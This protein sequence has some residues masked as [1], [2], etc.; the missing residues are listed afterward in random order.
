MHAISSRQNRFYKEWLRVAQ[1]AGG[2]RSNLILL[3]G[4]HLCSAWLQHVGAPNA[5]LL[6]QGHINENALTELCE[7]LAHD[8]PIYALSS[9]LFEGLSDVVSPQG[10]IFVVPKPTPLIPK[11]INQTCV[12]LDRIQDPGNLG[13]ILRT[14]AALEIKHVFLTPGTVSAWS[15]KVLRSAQGAHFLTAI[16]EQVDFAQWVRVLKIPLAL[17][18]LDSQSR[19][20]Y[21]SNLQGPIAWAFGNESQGVDLHWLS[22]AKHR[23]IIPHAAQI[24]SLNVSVAAAVC[25][26]EHRRQNLLSCA[27]KV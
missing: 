21:D 27:S 18:L 13:T 20:L 10:V 1:G 15:P 7:A 25:L 12:L 17:T 8:V 3:E 19:S 14:A 11:E 9:R 26:F 6:D 23:L 24:E 16:H 4:V 2:S 22:A 5:V